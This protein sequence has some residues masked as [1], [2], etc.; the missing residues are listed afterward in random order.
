[1]RRGSENYIIGTNCTKP[2]LDMFWIWTKGSDKKL[3]NIRTLQCMKRHKN[4]GNVTM[5]PCRKIFDRQKLKCE[6]HGSEMKIEWKRKNNQSH[7]YWVYLHL[8]RKNTRSV[9][10]SNQG[11]PQLW[12]CNKTY[13]CET[14]ERYKGKITTC[15]GHV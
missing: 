15:F 11:K 10:I 8:A 12:S 3:M 14:E 2:A 13:S 7:K 1:M 9:L 6:Q 5:E 4:G